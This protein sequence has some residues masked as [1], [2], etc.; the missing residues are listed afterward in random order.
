MTFWCLKN[1]LLHVLHI[2]LLSVQP[3][4]G[5]YTLMKWEVW[6]DNSAKEEEETTARPTNHYSGICI[7]LTEDKDNEADLLHQTFSQVKSPMANNQRYTFE[8]AKNR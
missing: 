5:F 3:K 2:K 7:N 1:H 4:H 6:S 8:N